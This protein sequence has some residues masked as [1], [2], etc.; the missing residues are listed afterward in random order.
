MGQSFISRE[1]AETQ[2]PF[3]FVVR[4][5]LCY[6][7]IA[8]TECRH[9]HLCTVLF[10]SYFTFRRKTLSNQGSRGVLHKWLIFN[11]SEL[12]MESHQQRGLFQGLAWFFGFLVFN[13]E[14]LHPLPA[15]NPPL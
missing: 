14:S 6:D 10:A 15:V 3:R 8:F 13:Y 5:C 12:C 9:W 11:L 7:C 1:E 2:S 4:L